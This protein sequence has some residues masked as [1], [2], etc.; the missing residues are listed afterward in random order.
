MSFVSVEFLIFLGAS[1]ALYYLLPR[2]LRWLLL[3]LASYGFYLTG[4]LRALSFLLLT[5]CST[6][7]AGLLL[8]GLNAQRKGADRAKQEKLRRKKKL[9]CTLTLLL[10]FG[11]LYVLKYLDFTLAAVASALGRFGL[12]WVPK[13]LNLLLPL[14]LSFY[15]FQSVGYVVD[16][17]RGKYP[18][19]HNLLKYALFTS[20]FPQMVQGPISRYQDLAP[21]LFEGH[22]L[23]AE[24]LRDGIQ[25]MLWGYFKK[26][27]LAD[28]TA[29]LVNA[30]FAD[31]SGYGG[32]VTAFA[33]LLYCINLYCD[34]S[35]GIDITRGA[36]QLFGIELAENFRRPIFATSLAEFWRRWHITLGSWMRDYVF[37][38]LSLSKPFGRL[39]KWSRKHIGGKLGKI[40]ATSLAT[41]IVYLLIG[42]WHG[43][44]FRFIAYGFWNGAIITASILLTNVFHRLR[45]KLHL[46]PKHWAWQGFS[47]LR[48]NLIV[49]IGRYITRAPRLL[50]AGALLLRTFNPRT[51]YLSQLWDGTLLRMGLGGGDLLILGLGTLGLLAL[52]WFQ[53]TKGPVRQTLARQS[54]L[55]QWLAM[56][57]PMA[58]ILFFGIFRGSYIASEF[59]YRQY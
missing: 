45:E 1:V 2:K 9:V 22:S 20:F 34:F 24:S 57:L 51:M 14:G 10:N 21:Q 39:G 33:M 28:R 31:F 25:L 16:Q 46:D 11:L 18:A 40:V 12:V 6:W 17:F 19:Q 41:F 35:G 56:L 38:P 32:G 7:A 29:V 8:E 5:T 3:L 44:N 48:T 4:G 52:E 15:M 23:K 42:L 54:A 53:E 43:A 49:F 59:I 36:A 30:F 58:V 55:V 26:M 27:V 37:Y 13:E 50:T 47:M